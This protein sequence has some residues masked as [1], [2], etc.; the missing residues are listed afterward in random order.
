MA[1]FDLPLDQLREYRA[2]VAEP[3]DF[4]AFW[5]DTIAQTRAA[6]WEPRVERTDTG[7]SLVETSDV[8]FSGFAGD[9]I[10]AWWHVP[11]GTAPRAVVVEFL[12]YSGGRGLPHE[13]GA[14]PLAGYAHLY[15][16]TRGQ[17]WHHSRPGATA[18]PH[19][20]GPS[21]PGKMTQGIDDPASYYYR[22]VFA[23]AFRAIETAREL[24][25]AL[26]PDVPLY[27][28][29]AS[30]GGG[31]AIAATALATSA[32]V[33]VAG[34]MPDVPFLCAF[35][36]ATTITDAM[37]YREI[38]NHLATHR[39]LQERVYRTL[40]YVDGVNFARRIT[41]PALFSVA[42][43][44]VICPPS[45]VFSAYN[46]WGGEDRAIEVYPFNDHEGGGAFQ[47]RAQLD[48]LA[49]RI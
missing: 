25:A 17:G 30:Q 22:R 8:V 12:G 6:A 35:P 40:S 1:L 13:V 24:G 39:G 28:T 38:A 33:P 10:R 29:G 47:R 46:S 11:S 44:D 26:A 9:E 20:S 14:W 43:M 2:D 4:D 41:V 42:L 15:V 45:T 16:D 49:A 18:D 23:D 32:G 34:V 21:A 48:W 5:A 36:R 7:L 27:V 3:S 19:G 31:I 37:P